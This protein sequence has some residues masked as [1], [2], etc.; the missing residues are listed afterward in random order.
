MGRM[1]GSPQDLARFMQQELRTMTPV[2]KRTVIS[3]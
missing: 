1:G 3:M 2:I